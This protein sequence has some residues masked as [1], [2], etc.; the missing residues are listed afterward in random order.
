MQ[1]QLVYF[2]PANGFRYYFQSLERDAIAAS[3]AGTEEIVKK[4]E[5]KYGEEPAY[6]VFKH[7]NKLL[8]DDYK[9]KATA[10]YGEQYIDKL[11]SIVAEEFRKQIEISA[12]KNRMD[13]STK[14]S[15][16]LRIQNPIRKV[17]VISN[18]R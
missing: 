7:A 8:D 16:Q 1:N 13:K 17:K 11:D 15:M 9:D 14:E 4:L 12:I 3:G 18:E 2:T 10:A 6:N 5:K